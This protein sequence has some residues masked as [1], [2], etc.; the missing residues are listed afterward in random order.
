[1][2]DY[3]LFI[4]SH[5]AIF[6]ELLVYVDDVILAGNDLHVIKETKNFLSNKFKLKNLGQLKYF[7]GI[8][9]A[10][11][12]HGINLSHRK[13]ALEILEGAGFLGAKPS[14][15]HVEQNILLRQSNSWKTLGRCIS[16][17]GRLVYLTVTRPDLTYG[18]RMC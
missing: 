1:M 9:V 6:L 3:S 16:V 11:S 7:L 12:H 5:Q 10:R 4:R 8:E 2:F 18:V 14:R 13:Y 15:F 17:I